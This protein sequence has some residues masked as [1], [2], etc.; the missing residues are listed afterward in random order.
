MRFCE[1]IRKLY[2]HFPCSN[3]GQFVLE[4]FSALCGETNPAG[5]NQESSNKNRDF[6]CSSF[7][8]T[9][10]TGDDPTY[11]KRLYG[12]SKKY[13]GLSSPIKTYIQGNKNKETFIAYCNFA[14]SSKVFPKLC[15]SF[16]VPEL[17]DRTVAFE[18]LYE[19]FIEFAISQNDDVSFVLPDV[20]DKLQNNPP[21]DPAKI[22]P[23]DLSPL[24]PGDNLQL[25]SEHPAQ[26]HVVTFYEEFDH[27]WI[28]KNTG[29]VTWIDR[30]FEFTNRSKTRIRPTKTKIALPKTGPGD[31]ACLDVRIDARHFEGTF[32]S[33]WEMKDKTG[34]LCFPDKNKALKVMATVINTP[35]TASEV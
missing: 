30:S 24:Y 18:G 35:N 28:I 20:I 14:I 32:E 21:K 2:K 34:R 13:S 7:L 25:I 11:R 23:E 26:N 1:F 31:E 8:P 16:E 19:Q 9:G 15:D 17:T 12:G 6:R 33:I 3:Q 22:T 5:S 4:I 29:T 27:Q 10:L